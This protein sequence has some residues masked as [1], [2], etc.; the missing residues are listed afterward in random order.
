MKASH[1]G[2]RS[3]PAT[4]QKFQST[5]EHLI[6]ENKE[7]VDK[8]NHGDK[9]EPLPGHDRDKFADMDRKGGQGR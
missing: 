2:Q 5:D 4:D 3:K 9:M 7:E 8:I 6:A 1:D